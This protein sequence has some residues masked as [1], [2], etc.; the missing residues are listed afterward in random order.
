MTYFSVLTIFP[1]VYQKTDGRVGGMSCKNLVAPQE[2]GD[3]NDAC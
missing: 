2:L 1:W 3:L